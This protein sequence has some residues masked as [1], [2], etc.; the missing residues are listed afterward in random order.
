MHESR[1]PQISVVQAKC[2]CPG[3]IDALSPEGTTGED[4][5]YFTGF[6]MKIQSE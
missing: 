6:P 1:H 2:H 5:F 3:G 4:E